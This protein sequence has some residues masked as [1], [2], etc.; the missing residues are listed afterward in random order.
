MNVLENR[1]DLQ[2]RISQPKGQTEEDRVDH[3]A[4]L[5]VQMQ[6]DI[7]DITSAMKH[8]V[9]ALNSLKGFTSITGSKARVSELLSIIT[10]LELLEEGVMQVLTLTKNKTWTVD[11]E[12]RYTTVEK[13]MKKAK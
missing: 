12:R 8:S 3:V 2:A 1:T 13:N 4:L 11:A 6:K 7:K 9:N 5:Q 10:A